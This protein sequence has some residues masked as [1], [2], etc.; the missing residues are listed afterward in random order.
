MKNLNKE[1]FNL[2]EIYILQRKSLKEKCIFKFYSKLQSI[3][4]NNKIVFLKLFY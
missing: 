1:H 2:T 3:M 4:N